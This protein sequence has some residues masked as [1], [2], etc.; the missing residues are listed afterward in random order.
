MRVLFDNG[1]SR[2][3][4]TVLKDHVV[5]E[6]R[7]RGWDVLRNGEL[8]DAA[9]AAG[10]E[11]VHHDRPKSSSPAESD[12]PKNRNR[13]PWQWSMEADQEQ[14]FCDCRGGG[15]SDARQLRRGRDS[16]YLKA[17]TGAT[18]KSDGQG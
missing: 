2:G 16:A 4:A 17:T 13:R 14:A 1:T 3:V 10:F 7:A 15:V 6:A 9:E 8:L 18:S 12:R 11:V 5:E